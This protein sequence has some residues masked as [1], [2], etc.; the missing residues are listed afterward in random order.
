MQNGYLDDIPVDKVKDFQGKLEEY[1]TTRKEGVMTK[2]RDE[3]AL[4]DDIVN[5]LKAAIEEFKSTY[6][7]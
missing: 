5:D 4:S 6:S 2:I 1:L 7:A 3:K